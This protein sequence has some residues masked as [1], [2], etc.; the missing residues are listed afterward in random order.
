MH[1]VSYLNESHG[2]ASPHPVAFAIMLSDIAA[3][4]TKAQVSAFA[5]KLHYPTQGSEGVLPNTFVMTYSQ[6]GGG[7]TKETTFLVPVVRHQMAFPYKRAG[8]VQSPSGNILS[9]LVLPYESIAQRAT[10]SSL[11]G[12][13][14]GSMARNGMRADPSPSKMSAMCQCIIPRSGGGRSTFGARKMDPRTT[15]TLVP[16]RRGTGRDANIFHMVRFV[17]RSS[18]V[19]LVL[20]WLCRDN[21]AGKGGGGTFTILSREL[22][23]LCRGYEGGDR[24]LDRALGR[25]VFSLLA[26]VLSLG[27]K[28][29]SA[30]ALF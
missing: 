17:V 16:E 3:V 7:Y 14:A 29:A 21:G 19:I 11:R 10:F 5:V 2:G 25:T 23:V 9:A 22:S 18:G 6:Y 1:P 8:S 26:G 12:D 27:K 20:G 28:A 24:W 15:Y 30:A 4:P 13:S